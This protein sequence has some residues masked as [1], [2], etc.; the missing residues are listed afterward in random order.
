MDL[1][2][3]SRILEEI[4]ALKEKRR[5]MEAEGSTKEAP[6]FLALSDLLDQYYVMNKIRLFCGFLSYSKFTHPAKLNYDRSAFSL[7]DEVNKYIDKKSTNTPI[8]K[9]YHHIQL[10]LAYSNEDNFDEEI[11]FNAAINLLDQLGDTSFPSNSSEALSLLNNYCIKQ[12]ND[13]NKGSH[14]IFEIQNRMFNLTYGLTEKWPATIPPAL[15]KNMVVLALRL[16]EKINFKEIYTVRLKSE[17][18]KYG[19]DSAFEWANLFIETY[20]TA[21]PSK[22]Q[23]KF[24]TFCKAYLAFHKGEFVKAFHILDHP[25]HLRGLFIAFDFKVLYLMILMELRLTQPALIEKNGVDL[26]KF[27]DKFRKGIEYEVVKGQQLSYH[28][29]YYQSFLKLF[30]HLLRLFNRQGQLYLHSDIKFQSELDKL[31][32]NVEKCIYPFKDWFN[33]KVVILKKATSK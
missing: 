17:D 33:K 20:N 32:D 22:D 14:R 28:L 24:Y 30:I 8:L 5:Q 4:Q 19:Y 1:D 9:L 18:Q 10:L 29:A 25:S 26:M 11:H 2:Y 12:Y 31:E 3:G 6:P 27:Y 16:K 23:K 13:G 21:L 15:Y 7:M